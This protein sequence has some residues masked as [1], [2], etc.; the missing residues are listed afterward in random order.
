M[1]NTISRRG[2]LRMAGAG[3]LG[4][5]AAPL[6]SAC[7]SGGGGGASGGVSNAGKQLVPWPAYVPFAGPKP[8]APG[9]A[10]GVQPLYLKYPE[11]LTQSV[12]DTVGDG[13][14]VTAL[15]V[16]FGPPPAPLA[17][18]RYWQ[19]INKALNVDL[20]ITVV[21]DPEYGQKMTTL[22]ASG[23][24][25][26]DIIMFTNL[27]LPHSLEFI[28]AQCADLSDHLAGDAV[29]QYPNLANIPTYA[30]KGMGRIGGRIY[31]VPLER[32]T[33]ANSLFVNRTLMDEAGI[34]KNWTT[35][36]YLDAMRELSGDRKWGLG[37]FKTLFS[38]LGGITYHAGSLGAPNTWSVVDGRFVSTITTPQFEQALDVMR[39]LVEARSVYPDSLTVSSTD[40]QSHFYNGTVASIQDGFGSLSVTNLAK[41]GDR[42]ELDMGYPYGP[43]ATPWQSAGLFGYVT[44]KKA[45]P[46]RIKLLLRICDY[47]SAPFGT[48][49][50]ELANYGVEGVHFTKDED[51][52]KTTD[53]FET[54]SNLSLPTR[55]IGA[56]PAV[57]YLPGHPDTA[58]AVHEWQ[59]ASLPGSVGNPANGL[60]SATQ[61]SKGA[62]MNQILG[63]GIAAI[64]FGR[65]PLSAWQDIVKQWRQAGGDQW[66]EELAKEYAAS[67]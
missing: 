37:W 30:W 15:V 3:A 17:Q 63:D 33:P 60:R 35:E 55:Y 29:K 66:A 64:A 27:A 65:K 46:E 62:Q 19:A 8:D 9:D 6:L 4:L 48:K 14:K 36:Q 13:S 32:P 7:G 12:T 40:M 22:M 21:P 5:A 58:K 1:D 51:G 50:Y 18:N 52:I 43:Q 61:V 49:E 44:F 39:K 23:S 45:A 20:Q 41:I 57:L 56:A 16:T 54:E 24:D 67:Q 34:P 38:G 42:F 2:L 59:K 47:L 31:G 26:P 10:P 11:T 28:Q 25:L 53:L